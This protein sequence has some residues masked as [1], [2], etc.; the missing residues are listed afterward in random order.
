MNHKSERTIVS[1]AVKSDLPL[2]CSCKDHG[3]LTRYGPIGLVDRGEKSLITPESFLV[4]PVWTDAS[5]PVA[6]TVRHRTRAAKANLVLT[7][8]PHL[9]MMMCW[10]G[11]PQLPFE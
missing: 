7:V 3:P 9:A 6:N 5:K 11:R 4:L 8:S 1:D 10:A 2:G